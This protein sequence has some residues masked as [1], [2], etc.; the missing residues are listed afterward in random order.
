MRKF[1]SVA[2]AAIMVAST[3][4]V[5]IPAMA[6]YSP[7]PV[8]TTTQAP[9]EEKPVQTTVNNNT[10]SKVNYTKKDDQ[11]KFTYTGGGTATGWKFEGLIEGKDY[12]IVSKSKD[13]KEIVIQLTEEGKQKQLNA[14]VT[15]KSNEQV[16]GVDTPSKVDKETNGNDITFEYTGSGKVEKVEFP[17][18]KEGVDY[19]VVKKD[20]NKVTIK[21]LNGVKPNQVTV[22]FKVKGIV[23]INGKDTTSK[24]VS[25]KTNKDKNTVTYT[26]KGKK[27]VKGWKFPGLKKGVDYKVVKKTKNSITIKLLNGTKSKYVSANVIV[28]SKKDSGSKSPATG[29]TMTGVVMAGAGVAMLTALKKK[30]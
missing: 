4:A 29:A 16:N 7:S 15:I 5:A 13:N 6:A 12:V 25:K 10:S 2:L 3:S 14:D 26:Y 19:K 27:T 24:T 21:L 28:K 9:V 8:I 11:Y 17:G 20:G 30:N 18:M 23:Q 22:N 1:V